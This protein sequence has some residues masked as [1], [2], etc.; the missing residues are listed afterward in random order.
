M[1]QMEQKTY[2]WHRVYSSMPA[3]KQSPCVKC[4]LEDWCI[5]ICPARAKWWD[6][7]ME[8]IRR[9][10]PNTAKDIGKR[11]CDGSSRIIF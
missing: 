4:R 5:D 9:K 7:C 10:L 8:R 1:T 2:N 6:V 11:N 3:P